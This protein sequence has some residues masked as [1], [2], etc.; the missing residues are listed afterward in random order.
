MG[1]LISYKPSEQ[2]IIFAKKL[3]ADSPGWFDH[4]AS[5]PHHADHQLIIWARENLLEIQ[6]K[7][8]EPETKH[9]DANKISGRKRKIEQ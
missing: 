7:P 4:V 5:R 9:A 8:P 1:S 3:Y 2:D 6:S